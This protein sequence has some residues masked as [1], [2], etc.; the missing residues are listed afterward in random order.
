MRK[1]NWARADWVTG[2]AVLLLM[3]AI[4]F[5]TGVF[6]ALDR[7]VFDKALLSLDKTPA[8]NIL[9]AAIDEKSL[10]NI[11]RWPWSRDVH[12]RG[13]DAI[14]KANAKTIVHTGLFFEPQTDQL[15]WVQIRLAAA[16]VGA[17]KETQG[18]LNA[19]KM[20]AERELDHDKALSES[21]ARAG[22]VM[23]AAR[24]SW[25]EAM[26]NAPGNI[27][28]SAPLSFISDSTHYNTG[29]RGLAMPIPLLA[30]SAAAV[31]AM[32]GITDADGN[33][34]R[35]PL[36]VNY[37]G[38]TMPSL[39]LAAAAHA[40]DQNWRSAPVTVGKGMQVGRNWIDSDE[41]SVFS[42]MRYKHRG[43]AQV[44]DSASFVDILQ[45]RLDPSRI[46]GRVVIIGATDGRVTGLNGQAGD[47]NAYP[48]PVE[49]VA[50]EI[51]S[52]LQGHTTVI[53][54]WS[55][56]VIAALV[57]GL[58]LYLLM[59][60]PRISG[61]NAIGITTA[62]CV[63]LVAAQY[64]A[65]SGAGVWV[66]LTLPLAL[67]VVTHV[68]LTSKRFL[69]T[70][71]GKRVSDAQASESNR[72]MAIALQGQGQLDAAYDRFR[73]VL[74][75]TDLAA[76]LRSLALDFERKRH[77]GKAQA[78]HEYILSGDTN[79]S[80]SRSEIVRLKALGSALFVPGQESPRTMVETGE[81]QR[82][83]NPTLGRYELTQELGRGSMGVVY[84]GVDPRIDRKV[85]IKTMALSNEYD[86]QEL[87]NAK[88]RFYREAKTA[89]RLQHPNIVTIHDVGEE[90][91]MAY[92]AMEVLS[93]TPLDDYL[94]AKGQIPINEAV[95][96]A[97]VIADA[98]AYAHLEGVVHRDI[99][100]ANILFRPNQMLKIT[101]FGIARI[102]DSNKTKTGVVMGT[103]AYMAP[104]QIRGLQ[105]DGRVDLYALGVMTFQLLTGRLPFEGESI[106]DLVYKI[107]NEPV[108]RVSE[109]RNDIPAGLDDVLQKAMAKEPEDRFSTGTQFAEALRSTTGNLI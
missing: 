91:G 106:H 28:E 8:T 43:Q 2:L 30:K 15:D 31:G 12:A 35:A 57:L 90:Q 19:L 67:L 42:P 39:A 6:A 104:E 63:V 14:A 4:N 50:G 22:N 27:F 1:F 34:R 72:E 3:L 97:A 77:F 62:I 92:I 44:F 68:A 109:Y 26:A 99:K 58:S 105:I 79:D 85:A 25:R 84:L 76:N 45:G 87:V 46:D 78:V 59:L 89:G 96:I 101:D 18:T 33:T 41:A 60:L 95:E 80:F 64:G 88:E 98:L 51:S 73:R 82:V 108:K 75:S 29:A 9:I 70:E 107:V 10:V 37:N 81:G 48:A 55:W 61:K 83:A 103:P 47:E 102:T 69:V 100:P 36:L 38:M 49:V 54:T 52:L 16:A 65:L 53:P 94:K 11:G 20:L 66:P 24:P 7:W 21:I 32:A 5:G 56:I 93:G 13:I 71:A 86:G 74:F 23:L 40:S 17:S